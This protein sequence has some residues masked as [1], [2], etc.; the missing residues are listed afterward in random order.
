MP[1]AQ[2][3][4]VENYDSA[5]ESDWFHTCREAGKPYVVVRTGE[6]MADVMWDYVTL[7]PSCDN[8][9]MANEKLLREQV[10]A[11]FEKHASV[12]SS[13]RAKATMVF[14]HNLII[15]KAKNAANELYSL[16]ESLVENP[17]QSSD[18]NSRCKDDSVASPGSKR[19][20]SQALPRSRE[21]RSDLRRSFELCISG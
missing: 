10:I 21:N 3:D 2:F 18:T 14:F 8:I 19:E 12:D 17:A 6:K 16:I 7:P 1:D 9:L 5:P 13:V 15:P 20:T 11:I 4:L